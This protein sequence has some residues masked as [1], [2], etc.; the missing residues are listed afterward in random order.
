MKKIFVIFL[1]LMMLCA[2]LPPCAAEEI[3]PRIVHASYNGFELFGVAEIPEEKEMWV[4]LTFFLPGNEFFLLF[5]P[6]EPDGTFRAY[7]LADCEHL[8]V[9]IVDDP[10]AIVPGQYTVYD[11]SGVELR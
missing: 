1:T 9:Q 2:T 6:I 11:A 5:A 4:R 10:Y 7:V 8:A 3:N